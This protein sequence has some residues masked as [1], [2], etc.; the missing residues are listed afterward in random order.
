MSQYI[1]EKPKGF[2][3]K[4]TNSNTFKKCPPGFFQYTVR[5]GDTVANLARRLGV[6]E[7]LIIANIPVDPGRIRP[8]MVICLP[9]PVFFP[10]CVVLSLTGTAPAA[11]AGAA[12][13]RQLGNGRQE[14][15]FLASGLPNPSAFGAFN[16]FE[17]FVDIRGIGGFA[18]ILSRVPDEPNIWAGG[19]ELIRPVLFAG[20]QIS[21]RPINT[22]TGLSGQP[23]LQGDLLRCAVSVSKFNTRF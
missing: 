16:A 6:D 9:I 12:L 3:S 23:V 18:D 5:P 15:A 19:V 2:S 11:A 4:V 10:C 20:A 17:G 14:V 8:G 1:F 22:A 7:G 13:I 21:I